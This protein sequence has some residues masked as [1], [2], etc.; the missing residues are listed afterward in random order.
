MLGFSVV[1]VALFCVLGTYTHLDLLRHAYLLEKQGCILNF[2]LKE[3]LH[4]HDEGL[5]VEVSAMDDFRR[6]LEDDRPTLVYLTP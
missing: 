2:L 6:V 3:V 1:C 5:F 4:R